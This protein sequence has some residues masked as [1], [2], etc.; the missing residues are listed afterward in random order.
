MQLTEIVKSPK[1]QTV[2]DEARRAMEICNACRYCEGYCAVF[3]A[4]ELRRSFEDADLN[5]LANLCHNCRGCYYSCQYAPPHPF[6]LNLPKT[7]QKLRADSYA[8]YAWPGPLARLFYRNGVVVSL[9]TALGVALVFLLTMFIQDSSVLFASHAGP[10]AFYAVIPYEV[11]VTVAGLTFGFAIVALIAGA[12]N[13]WRD[14]GARPA[15]KKT[16][17]SLMQALRDAMTLKYLGGGTGE[18]C[19]Y[20]DEAFSNIRRVYHHFMF[21]GFMLCFAS[22]TV[23]TIYDHVFGWIA[24]YGWFSIPVIL[25]TLGGIGLLIGP[26]GL[27]SLKFKADTEPTEKNL[28]GMDVAF[29]AL[30][31]LVSLTGLALLAFRETSAMGGILAIHLGFVF[32]LFAVLPYSKFVHGIYRSAAL[33]R[34]AIE[35][36]K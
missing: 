24:P 21:Y 6:N 32:T 16:L 30:L 33:L 11:M 34:Y 22:T 14:A 15:E 13:Y 19:T 18:G 9:L 8:Q 4:M 31:F 7:F 5:Y 36:R 10:G 25:G 35:T 1:Q 20:P 26:A 12:I 29:L 23:A 3:P 27:I 17:P 28:M 2:I